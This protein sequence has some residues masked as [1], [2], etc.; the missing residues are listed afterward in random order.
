M[1]E[2]LLISIVILCIV[3]ILFLI[4]IPIMIAK[5]RGVSGSEL[6]TITVLSWLGIFLGITWIVALI[7]ALVWQPAKW[8]DKD[9]AANAG[10]IADSLEKLHKLKQKG[11]ITAKEF[12]AEK[13]KLLRN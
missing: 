3:F 4:Q 12:E 1:A 7:L 2:F 6:S 11:V 13:K 5:G 8:L 10:D 9:S